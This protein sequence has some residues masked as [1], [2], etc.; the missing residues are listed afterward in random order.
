LVSLLREANAIPGADEKSQDETE[1]EGEHCDLLSEDCFKEIVQKYPV[2]MF[3][4]SWCPECKR[5]LELLDRMGVRPHIIDLDDYK[6]IS[7]DIRYHMLQMT[8]RRS[9][10]NLFIDGEYIGG[11]TRTYEM[12]EKG[13]LLPK[14]QKVGAIQT[15]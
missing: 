7:Q 3:S 5:S 12:Y 14:F 9:V 2:L 8:G 6:P 11:F 13:E 4:L 10:P 15:E 1:N